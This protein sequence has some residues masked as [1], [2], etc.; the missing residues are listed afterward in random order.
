MGVAPTYILF[1][2]KKLLRE[3]KKE[4]N[5]SPKDGIS[6]KIL[7]KKPKNYINNYYTNKTAYFKP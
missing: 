5:T 6:P 7:K 1:F 4:N 2:S 3:E